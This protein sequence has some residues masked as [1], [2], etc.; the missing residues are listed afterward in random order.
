MS[1]PLSTRPA[2]QVSVMM[3]DE[4]IDL[5]DALRRDDPA[6]P[7]RSEIA[8]NLIWGAL[9]IVFSE[10]PRVIRFMADQPEPTMEGVLNL[11]KPA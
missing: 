7:S 2:R 9:S 1:L 6:L 4:L 8:R 10:D 11:R 3:E 5:L